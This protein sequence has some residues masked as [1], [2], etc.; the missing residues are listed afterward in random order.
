MGRSRCST[1]NFNQTHVH[2]EL[3]IPSNIRQVSPWISSQQWASSTHNGGNNNNFFQN[4]DEVS[5]Q[6]KSGNLQPLVIS[7]P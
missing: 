7:Y 4:F 6:D 3:T 2:K 5:Q 1:S